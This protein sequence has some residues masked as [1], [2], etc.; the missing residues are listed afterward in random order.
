MIKTFLIALLIAS[1]PAQALAAAAIFSGTNVKLLKQNLDFNGAVSILSGTVNPSSSA[2]SAPIGSL[3]LNTSTG[4]SYQKQDSGSST[5]WTPVF[6]T[7]GGTL[8]SLLTLAKGSTAGLTIGDVST[9]S[10]SVIRLQGTS[11]GRNWQLANNL[12]VSGLEITPSTANGGTTYSTPLI[13]ITTSGASIVPAS[14]NLPLGVSGVS[15]AGTVTFTNPA[16]NGKYN[17]L[18]GGQYVVNNG[19]EITPSTATN[20]STFS[21]PVFTVLQSGQAY[22]NNSTT[23][24]LPVSSGTGERIER[25]TINYAGGTPSVVSQSGSWIA[26]LTDS[27]VGDLIVNITGSTFSSAPTCTANARTGGV[28]FANFS[29]AVTTSAIRMAFYT[30]TSGANTDPTDVHIICMGPK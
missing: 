28:V 8:T 4:I 17:W 25:A 7:A 26:S 13:S 22:L 21:T 27:A 16:A 3:Y 18:I 5:N 2:T 6:T 24:N 11:A 15:S 30:S 9:N 14:G 19:F 20:G 1:A 10:N 23:Q 29:V 12:N